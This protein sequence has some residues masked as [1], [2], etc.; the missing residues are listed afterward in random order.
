[1]REKILEIINSS[2]RNMNAMEIMNK[3]NSNSSVD[4]L[5]TLIHELDLMCRDGI[6]RTASGNTY[7]KNDLLTFL[8]LIYDIYLRYRVLN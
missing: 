4:E 3:I 2:N 1:M 5:R 8:S 6:L 7:K